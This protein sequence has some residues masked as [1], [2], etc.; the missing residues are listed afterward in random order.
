MPRYG[1]N[2]LEIERSSM[3]PPSGTLQHL[4][5]VV[6]TVRDESRRPGVA[7]A[8]AG[9]CR[10]HLEP[11]VAVDRR[12]R[13]RAE[14]RRVL[15]H[16][17]DEMIGQR[18]EAQARGSDSST[19]QIAPARGVGQ[20]I[21]HVRTRARSA[22]ERL[23]HERRDRTRALGK[24][25]GHHPEES[26]AIGGLEGVGVPEVDLVLEIGVFVIALIDA[27]AQ[28]LESVIERAQETQSARDSLV[29]VARLR[30]VVDSVRVPAADRAVRVLDDQEELGLDADVEEIAP[31]A[32]PRRGTA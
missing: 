32:A 25:A 1:L 28:A 22:R 30:Q 8:R 17:A 7:R 20:V 19:K 18:R 12:R 21:V 26:V 11:L 24:L 9:E 27:P 31:L 16:S 14:R 4:G 13:D 29:V 5:P 3:C 10:P 2:A 15:E 6:V 23:G